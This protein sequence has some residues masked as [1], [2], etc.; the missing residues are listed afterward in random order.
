MNVGI[1]GV[2]EVGK[3]IY[4]LVTPKHTVFV[5]DLDRNEFNGETIDILHICIPY[6]DRFN[7][8]VIHTIHQMK[9]SL[10]II[11]STVAVG[12]TRK[13]FT[14]SKVPIVHSPVRGTHPHLLQGIQTF[15]KFI[16]SMNKKT[17]EKASEYYRQLGVTTSIV[18]KPEDTELAKLLDTTYYAW[19]VVFC[20]AVHALCQKY[21]ID[22][23]TAY[24]A[25][26][27]TY[28][29]GYTKL[30]RHDVVRPILKSIPGGFGGHCL[31]ENAVILHKTFRTDFENILTPILQVGKKNEK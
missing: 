10:V 2:G 9:P 7:D 3:A 17:G 22:F 11:E 16:G 15:V 13:I 23:E 12:T 24:T 18:S 8:I 4:K 5:K 29:E 19:A 31:W 25:F 1:L 20:K 27:Q 30:G 26:N 28:N 14:A 21:G 6:T